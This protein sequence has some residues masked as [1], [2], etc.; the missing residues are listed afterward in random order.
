MEVGPGGLFDPPFPYEAGGRL[1]AARRFHI[2]D[3]LGT[4]YL[5]LVRPDFLQHDIDMAFQ[6]AILGG[7]GRCPARPTHITPRFIQ[8]G[9]VKY[10]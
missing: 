4:G 9:R 7:E 1:F 3:Q 10:D 8:T 5:H 2:C 6:L